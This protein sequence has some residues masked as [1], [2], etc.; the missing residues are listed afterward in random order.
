MNHLLG[1]QNSDALREAHQAVQ[2]EVVDLFTRIG[3]S[4]PLYDAMVTIRDT[5]A[6]WAKLD[7]AQRRVVESSIRDMALSGVGL[8]GA[9]KERFKAIKL[10]LSQL[11]TKFSNNVLDSTKAYSLVITDKGELDGLP[12]M[13]LD[14]FAQNAAKKGHDGQSPTYLGSQSGRQAGRP[15]ITARAVIVV[16]IDWRRDCFGW[17]GDFNVS[18][19]HRPFPVPTTP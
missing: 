8:D 3:Q 4:R 5:P 13:F 14:L 6:E 17:R 9:E 7:A 1:V 18:S 11:S 16:I 12:Q 19:Q 15:S 10:E 2:P